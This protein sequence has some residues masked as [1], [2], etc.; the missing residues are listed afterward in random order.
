MDT[1]LKSI[2]QHNFYFVSCLLHMCNKQNLKSLFRPK[3]SHFKL[4]LACLERDIRSKL[5]FRRIF[6][7]QFVYYTYQANEKQNECSCNVHFNVIANSD[8]YSPG[9]HSCLLSF[10][11]FYIKFICLNKNKCTNV[12]P[13]TFNISD[14]GASG[15]F[16][17]RATLSD[18]ATHLR[19]YLTQESQYTQ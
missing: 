17:D 18:M 2:C 3:N 14:S 10:P 12:S 7:S 15:N 16:S 11:S 5:L 6:R 4:K 9:S 1:P 8:N 19:P 13:F